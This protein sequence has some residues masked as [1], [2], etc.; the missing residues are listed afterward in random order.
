MDEQWIGAAFT[1]EEARSSTQRAALEVSDELVAELR[2]ATAVVIG[3]PMHNLTVPSTLKAYI[4]Q[5][6]RIGVTTKLVPDTPH[7]PYVGLLDDKPTYLM[8]VRGGYGYEPG[9]AYAP[10]NFQEPY[11]TAVLGML[12]IRNVQALSLEYSTIDD[13]RFGDLLDQINTR[14]DRIFD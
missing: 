8:F 7:S 13:S 11:L 12:G 4:D 3:C 6:I 14:I 2:N 10:L 1:P 9:Q 5:V